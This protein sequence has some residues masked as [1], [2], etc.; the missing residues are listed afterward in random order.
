V[1]WGK[2]SAWTPQE[3]LKLAELFAAGLSYRD[4]GA[5]MGKNH[6]QVAGR[7][8]RAKLST[9]EK[10]E[11]AKKVQP[12]AVEISSDK[13]AA[14]LRAKPVQT[15][16]NFAVQRIVPPSIKREMRDT[17]GLVVTAIAT[18]TPVPLKG[19]CRYPMWGSGAPTDTYCDKPRFQLRSSYCTEHDALCVV[20]RVNLAA[21]G[22]RYKAGLSN[23][24]L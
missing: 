6:N 14:I 4:I 18:A 17:S 13:K 16:L 5:E 10:R 8:T 21:P 15:V 20:R 7:L 24:V 23:Y 12:I 2:V 19:G 22:G 11:F 9:G 1:V 3:D